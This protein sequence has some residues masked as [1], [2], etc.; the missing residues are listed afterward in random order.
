MDT[1]APKPTPQALAQE[2][3][4]NHSHDLGLMMDYF[5]KPEELRVYGAFI[6]SIRTLAESG[7]VEGESLKIGNILLAWV[8]R[9]AKAGAVTARNQSELGTKAISLAGDELSGGIQIDPRIVHETCQKDADAALAIQIQL[10]KI[11]KA[12]GLR[13]IG[14][15]DK[16]S[17]IGE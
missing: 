15:N 12:A 4:Q 10:G 17:G 5:K 8:I 11:L 3:L 7:K 16:A 13:N 9:D 6:N 2:L 1:P 14:K